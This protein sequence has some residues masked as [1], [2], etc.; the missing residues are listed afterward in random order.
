MYN[1]TIA[2]ANHSLASGGAERVISLLSSRFAEIGYKT[3]LICNIHSD[4]EYPVNKKVERFYLNDGT[5]RCRAVAAF[6]RIWKLRQIC[7]REKVDVLIG[8]MSM[9]EYSVYAT[10]GL[11]TRNIISI[12][13]APDLLYPGMFKKIYTKVLLS[14]SDGAVFQ[15]PDARSWFT[16]SLQEKSTIIYNPVGNQFY[17]KEHKPTPRLLVATGRLHEQK[18]YKLLI[19]AVAM[20]REKYDVRLDIYG[21][22]RLE[23]ELKCFVSDLGLNDCVTFR[24]QTDDI[25]S[26]IANAD[27]FVLSSNFEGMPNGL[28][29]AMA[30]GIPCVAT[31]SPCGGSR[32]LIGQNERGILVPV[33]DKD[34]FATAIIDLLE[35]ESKKNT[36]ALNAK[37]FANSFIL[38]NV[39]KEWGDYISQLVD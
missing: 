4:W 39:T 5:S 17:I 8:F 36:V 9:S 29:E 33:E 24:G 2:F 14:F 37:E 26:A 27:I 11:K 7:K 28:M 10:I 3:L 12:R 35:N 1:N 21:R 19:S 13:N 18:N 6:Q 23:K 32:M 16:K 30:M 34:S 15:T 25:P 31:D 20:V 38:E 22:G